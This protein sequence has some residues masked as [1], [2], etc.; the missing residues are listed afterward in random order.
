MAHANYECCAVC[1]KKVYY[2]FGDVYA[3]DVI[4]TNCVVELALRGVFIRNVHELHEWMEK[5]SPEKVLEILE[6]VGF[7]K[8][9]YWNEIDEL[10]DELVSKVQ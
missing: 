10:Y 4:C 8:C 1:D 5:E 2:A 7:K 9:H 3:K 6:Q